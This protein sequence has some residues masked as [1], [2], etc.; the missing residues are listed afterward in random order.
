MTQQ[1]HD[2]CSG[3]GV[4]AGLVAVGARVAA[5]LSPSSTTARHQSA[6]RATYIGNRSGESLPKRAPSPGVGHFRGRGGDIPPDKVAWYTGEGLNAPYAGTPA[7]WTGSHGPTGLPGPKLVSS[8]SEPQLQW[9]PNPLRKPDQIALPQFAARARDLNPPRGF[10][11]SH[12]LLNH[13]RDPKPGHTLHHAGVS[14]LDLRRYYEA[15]S[16]RPPL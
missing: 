6:G 16:S 14:T 1:L 8:N 2:R 13:G 5:G 12:A 10:E 11:D 3:V 15:H 7:L 4:G 9:K